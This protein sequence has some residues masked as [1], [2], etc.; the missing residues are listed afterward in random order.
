MTLFREVQ[1]RS[2]LQNAPLAEEY[3]GIETRREATH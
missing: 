3:Q 2:I 1:K